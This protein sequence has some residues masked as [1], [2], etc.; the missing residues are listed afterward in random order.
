MHRTPSLPPGGV[1]PKGCAIPASPFGPGR[2]YVYARSARKRSTGP[3][4][5]SPHPRNSPLILVVVPCQATTGT[6]A[7]RRPT[8][9]AR[10][11][12]RSG[13]RG[14]VRSRR[15]A[16]AEAPNSRQRVADLRVL[17]VGSVISSKLLTAYAFVLNKLS[18]EKIFLQ[19]REVKAPGGLLNRSHVPTVLF[20]EIPQR[21]S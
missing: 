12:L 16:C 15:H 3:S 4:P 21:S 7:T 9:V 17:K 20:G 1:A 8:A 10:L 18:H 5:C 6:H 14:A 13:S 19:R 2:T 11:N